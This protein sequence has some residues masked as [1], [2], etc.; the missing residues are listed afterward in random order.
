VNAGYRRGRDVGI[1]APID[2]AALCACFAAEGVR[3]RSISRVVYLVPPFVIRDAEL[4]ALTGTI[5]RAVAAGRPCQP[6]E[7]SRLA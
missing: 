4:E 3:I 5:R 2:A 7:T 1:E 6:G